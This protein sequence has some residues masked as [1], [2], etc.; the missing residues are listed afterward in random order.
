MTLGTPT[1]TVGQPPNQTFKVGSEAPA[2]RYETTLRSSGTER[3]SARMPLTR[4]L[5]SLFALGL[6][7]SSLSAAGFGIAGSDDGL[8]VSL[9]CAGGFLSLTATAALRYFSDG[10]I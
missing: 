10:R 4:R 1:I 9:L 6:S 8:F 3:R 2:Q 7:L 5:L